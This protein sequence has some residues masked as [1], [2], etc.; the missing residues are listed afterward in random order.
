MLE[1]C[2]PIKGRCVCNV[3]LCAGPPDCPPGEEVVMTMGADPE[4]GK[5]CNEYACERN[6]KEEMIMLT[7]N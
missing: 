1:H 2:C 4:K 7:L 5:C 3:T 6:S